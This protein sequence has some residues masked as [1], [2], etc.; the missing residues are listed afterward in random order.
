VITPAPQIER[1]A[2]SGSVA[3]VASILAI[4]LQN[5]VLVPVLLHRWTADT[6]GIWITLFAVQSLLFTVN[7][8]QEA[9]VGYEAA[10][11]L[12]EDRP[13]LPA[14]IGAGILIGIVLGAIEV[15]LILGLGLTHF[16]HLFGAGPGLEE[17]WK[18]LAI[19]VGCW[20]GFGSSAN[21]LIRVAYALG[22][23]SRFT[24]YSVLFRVIVTIA[25]AVSASF[26]ASVWGA[27]MAYGVAT[28]FTQACL[29]A[30]ALGVIRN[31]HIGIGRPRR[32]V[33]SSI[34]TRS[35]VVSGTSLLD[36]FS[37]NGLLTIISS[38]LSPKLV[39]QFS[40]LRTITNTAKQGVGIIMHP[41]DP[42]MI[43]Y[44][45]KREF[46]KL[47]EIFG[48]CWT[49]AGSAI[50]FGLCVLP[51]FIEPVYRVWTRGK[52]PFNF[53]LFSLLALSVAFR[54]LGH[55]ALAFLQAT[56]DIKAQARISVARAIMVISLSLAFIH[57]FGLLGVGA[58]LAISEL[59]GA[60]VLPA[61]YAMRVFSTSEVPFPA[62]RMIAAVSSVAI[63]G[64]AF[65]SCLSFPS[66]KV[67]FCGSAS[68]AIAVLA[69]VQWVMLHG[70]TR[71]RMLSTLQVL[72]WRSHP[73]AVAH[74]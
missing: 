28:L 58:A 33:I 17:G 34:L 26:G 55:P 14:L 22:F 19:V 47:Y 21:I 15:L 29:M 36:A 31:Y 71:R 73:P 38:V 51:V 13:A 9:Y 12:H 32:A 70:E 25:I 11:L 59:I 20:I 48:V 66:L 53:P 56:N 24:L 65:A 64:I 40:T 74:D 3:N 63:V 42:D 7:Y 67:I 39:P 41:L 50:N 54:T 61:W 10:R 45:A 35:A 27:V 46:A 44:H 1:R 5:V 57:P 16:T 69:Y 8:G 2:L 18:P 72:R 6:Y 4:L 37:D 49:V 60:A 23:Y 43:R 68:T 62:P 52:L 30:M